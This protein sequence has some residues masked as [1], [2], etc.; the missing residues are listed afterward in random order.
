MPFTTF[1]RRHHCRICGQI[2]CA[3]CCNLEIAGH[4]L[5]YVGQLRVCSFCARSVMQYVNVSAATHPSIRRDD[6]NISNLSIHTS[7][8]VDLKHATSTTSL[9]NIIASA[10]QVYS[11]GKRSLFIP[12]YCSLFIEVSHSLVK[13]K[14]LLYYN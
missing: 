8:N 4:V 13:M 10:Q 14:I 2:F 12:H 1:R 9:D 7:D 3:R 11:P 6:I 5:G